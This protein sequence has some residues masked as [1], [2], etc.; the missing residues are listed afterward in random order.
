VEC[1]YVVRAVPDR[2]LCMKSVNFDLRCSAV[3]DLVGDNVDTLVAGDSLYT[4][5]SACSS[6]DVALCGYALQSPRFGYR[7]PDRRPT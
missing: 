3:R 4:S 2:Q 1:Q 5:I 6:S 7:N